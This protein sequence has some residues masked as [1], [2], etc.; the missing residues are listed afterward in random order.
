[1]FGDSDGTAMTGPNQRQRTV[2]GGSDS[3]PEEVGGNLMLL[4]DCFLLFHSSA[5][6]VLCIYHHFLTHLPILL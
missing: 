1:M 4:L 5:A 2:P 6:A 3:V